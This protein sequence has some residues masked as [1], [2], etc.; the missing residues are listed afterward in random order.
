MATTVMNVRLD[1]ETKEALDLLAREMDR[2]RA[3]L[4]ARAIAEYVQRN[5]W[6]IAAIKEGI[7]QLDAG[8][9]YDYDDVMAELD[10]IIA[11]EE[12]GRAG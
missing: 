1:A 8:Q 11:G 7:R 9:S 5:A 4:A 10:G 2:P 6:Q 3:H 12:A